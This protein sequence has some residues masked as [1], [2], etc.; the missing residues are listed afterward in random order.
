MAVAVVHT[1]WPGQQG[2]SRSGAECRMSATSVLPAEVLRIIL[3][4]LSNKDLSKVV[5]VCKTWRELGEDPSLW[6][7][8][9]VAVYSNMYLKKTKGRRGDQRMLGL[10]RLEHVKNISV[11]RHGWVSGE[12]KNLFK[13]ML[14]LHKLS[15]LV[16]DNFSLS[17]VEPGLVASVVTMMEYMYMSATELS[18]VQV[19]TLFSTISETSKL[20]RL[21]IQGTNLSTV[22][23]YTLA[24]GV[25]NIND[26]NLRNTQVTSEQVTCILSEAAK[27]TKLHTLALDRFS[28]QQ[29]DQQV[30][31]QAEISIKDLQIL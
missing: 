30:V 17:F 11:F 21:W 3:R 20:R 12:L 13:A 27:H 14:R 19:D 2:R 28:V 18:S 22:D 9:T 24:D 1:A 16:M 4:K 29:V 23:K 31:Q 8:D 25:N 5:L 7:W 10:R 6:K 26:V 15:W